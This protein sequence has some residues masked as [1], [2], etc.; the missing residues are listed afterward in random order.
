MDDPTVPQSVK[1]NIEFTI[2]MTN[3]RAHKL[4]IDLKRNNTRVAELQQVRRRVLDDDR[5][6]G[7][8][9]IDKDVLVLY[10][11]NVSRAHF[12]RKMRNLTH[13]V[14]R[15]TEGDSADY[16]VFEYFRY[17]SKAHWTNPNLISMYYGEQGELYNESSNVFK[18][19]SENGYI[20]GYFADL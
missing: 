10:L 6:A 4:N 14:E 18:Y 1:D 2:D 3:D 7:R 15:M 12:H 16:E 20:S 8:R 9:R 11:D 19:F 5:K 17:H 13:W